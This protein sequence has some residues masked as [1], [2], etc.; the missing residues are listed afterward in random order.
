M[1]L[2]PEQMIIVA[3]ELC[4]P[5]QLMTLSGST[6]TDVVNLFSMLYYL[7]LFN[8]LSVPNNSNRETIYAKILLIMVD[9]L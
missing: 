6:S 9:K 5:P 8:A 4:L 2:S 3:R 1:P 7:D